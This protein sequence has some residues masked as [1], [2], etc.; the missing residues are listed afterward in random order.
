M[1][2]LK[3]NSRRNS[4]C[5]MPL[6]R[7]DWSNWFTDS[8]AFGPGLYLHVHHLNDDTV[9]RVFCKHDGARRLSMIDGELYWL[10][11]EPTPESE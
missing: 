6:D 8:G 4:R 5:S 7:L 1:R 3:I 10:I 9:H 11:D 2:R